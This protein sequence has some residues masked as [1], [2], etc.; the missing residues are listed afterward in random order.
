MLISIDIQALFM[1]IPELDSLLFFSAMRWVTSILLLQ[2]LLSHFRAAAVRQSKSMPTSAFRLIFY[3][4]T[5]YICG[6]ENTH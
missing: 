1:H 3:I 5:C 6:K 4:V 2:P